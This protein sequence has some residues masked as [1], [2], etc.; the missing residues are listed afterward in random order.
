MTEPLGQMPRMAIY[1][2]YIHIRDESW[3]KVAALYWPRMV[4]IV[5]PDYPT[6]NSDLVAVLQDELG[7][8]LDE[9]PDAAARELA[10][11]FAQTIETAAPD[12]LAQLR[13][14]KD[15]AGED[16]D[17]LIEPRPPAEFDVAY[18]DGQETCVPVLE[19]YSMMWKSWSPR[20][21][22]GVHHSE[23]APQLTEVLT[24]AG[25]AVPARGEWLAMNPALAWIYKSRL[26]EEMARRNNLVP[27]TD[28]VTAHA[29]MD[30]PVEIGS[31][32]EL[33]GQSPE[34][35]HDDIQTRFG[36]LAVKAVI[37]RN[38]DRV[39]EHKIV[40]IRQRFAS[41]FDLWRAYADAVG[42]GLSHQLQ[43][44]ESPD[45]LSAYLTDAVRRY[46][47]RPLDDLERGLNDLGIDTA[48]MTVSTKFSVPAGLAAA[49]LTQPYVATAAGA[50]LGI[51]GLRQA[52]RQ[53]A[54]A[55]KSTPAAYLLS[56]NETLAPQT[57]LTRIMAVMRQAAGL[58]G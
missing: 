29:V 3:L 7:F 14:P 31:H 47:T 18:Q 16:P 37:P 45:I 39:P 28:Q 26:T 41:Q 21:I 22:A 20:D 42:T 5:S 10:R 57:W 43:D 27:A 52:T 23:M 48:T 32:A 24:A 6:R 30:G 50:A 13:V 11:P 54:Q 36:L 55:R 51:A 4:R 19:R 40:Q 9:P 53:K 33:A 38:L 12:V 44:V 34:P 49:G 58:S 2:P 46:A 8:I 35:G 17:N 1:Y 56:I 25:L 15:A